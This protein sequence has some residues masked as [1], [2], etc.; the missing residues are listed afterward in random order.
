MSDA[1]EQASEEAQAEAATVSHQRHDQTFEPDAP[2]PTPYDGEGDDQADG[3]EDGFRE[4]E[5]TG[6]RD[7]DGPNGGE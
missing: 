4:T 7:G 3:P 2:A 1:T 6:P 5:G